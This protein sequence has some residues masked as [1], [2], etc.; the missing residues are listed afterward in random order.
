MSASIPGARGRKRR[1]YVVAVVLGTALSA[2]G[3]SVAETRG[4][5]SPAAIDNVSR[6]CTACW[7]NAHLPADLWCDCTQDVFRRLLLR[8]EP[9]EWD[10]LLARDGEQRRQ[11]VRAIDAVK[12]QAR[13]QQRRSLQV[14]GVVADASGSEQEFLVEARQRVDGAASC[15]LSDRQR[16]ILAMSFDG[17]SVREIGQYLA[18]PVARVSDE[19]YKA[20]RKLREHFAAAEKSVLLPRAC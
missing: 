1:P 8:V 14:C 20:I 17:W 12:K 19:K 18:L 7:R 4:N 13:R 2:L 3:G 9:A 10:G 5:I 16:R 15:L 6:Y 11:L